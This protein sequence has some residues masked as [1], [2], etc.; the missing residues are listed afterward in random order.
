M[1][2]MTLISFIDIRPPACMGVA[3]T[4]MWTTTVST[5]AA[6]MTFAMMGLR[7]SART[8]PR[9]RSPGAERPHPPRITRSTSGS[10]VRICAIRPRGNGRRR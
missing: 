5:W 8:N 9:R 4:P 6:S 10:W 7:I 2:P 1:V 3:M